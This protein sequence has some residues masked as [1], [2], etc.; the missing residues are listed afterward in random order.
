MLIKIQASKDCGNSPKNQFVQKIAL[1]L[2]TG[3]AG[4]EDFS[5]DVVWERS[6][7]ERSI[8]RDELNRVF[9]T[10]AAPASITIDHAISHGKVGVASGYVMLETG[11]TRR[12]S[13]VLEFTNA[14]ASCVAAI[15]SYA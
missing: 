6:M 12:F 9:T 5:E 7:H 15:K 8:G 2:E 1:A 10:R 11:E 3:E 4:P 13:H 14:K